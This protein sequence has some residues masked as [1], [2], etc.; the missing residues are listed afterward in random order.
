MKGNENC[1]YRKLLIG[2]GWVVVWQLLALW[3][4]N[5]LLLSTPGQTVWKLL[6]LLKKPDFYRAVG[7]TLL[8]I[9]A[10]AM[11]GF[12][13]AAVLAAGSSPR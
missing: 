8:R 1:R 9:S 2:L 3:V 11:C 10:G 4:D 6:I 5:P 7:S 13:A 12:L